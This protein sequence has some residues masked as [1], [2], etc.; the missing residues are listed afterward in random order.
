MFLSLI[1]IPDPVLSNIS[2]DRLSSQVIVAI[3]NFHTSIFND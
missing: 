1:S 2:N 3:T